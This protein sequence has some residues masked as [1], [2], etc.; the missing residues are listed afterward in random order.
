ME[1][2]RVQTTV[3]EAHRVGDPRLN[4]RETVLHDLTR[5]MA[6]VWGGESVRY[7]RADKPELANG[8]RN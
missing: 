2:P 4:Q 8:V 5:A 7:T 6:R 3:K 1:V